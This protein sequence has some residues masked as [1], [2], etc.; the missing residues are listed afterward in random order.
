MYQRVPLAT[1]VVYAGNQVL[2]GNVLATPAVDSQ[3]KRNEAYVQPLN[4]V[5]HVMGNF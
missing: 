5:M 4:I 1:N 3:F 2:V